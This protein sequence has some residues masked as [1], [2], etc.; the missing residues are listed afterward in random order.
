MEPQSRETFL[1]HFR[2]ILNILKLTRNEPVE[3]TNPSNPDAVEQ[4][5]QEDV[6]KLL[7]EIIKDLDEDAPDP[8]TVLHKAL[9]N[10][11][12]VEA[13]AFILQNLLEQIK[14]GKPIVA[15][16]ENYRKL[17]L[18]DLPNI[19]STTTNEPTSGTGGFLRRIGGYLK[20]VG[21]TLMQLIVNC[22]QT[23]PRFVT[24]KPSIG[25]VGGFV[26]MISFELGIDPVSL[27]DLFETLRRHIL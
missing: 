6:Q 15:T 25:L 24:V 12:K 19:S 8:D 11:S 4:A 3:F 1:F 9:S 13:K 5:V 27:A 26:P 14:S 23:I 16:V 18:L 10:L 20:K 21:L 2:N 22:M 7:D 17:G